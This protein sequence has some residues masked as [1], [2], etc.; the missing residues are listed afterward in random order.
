MNVLTELGPM[1]LAHTFRKPQAG[2]LGLLRMSPASGST[3]RLLPSI[4]QLTS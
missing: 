4:G 1:R 3:P 2:G